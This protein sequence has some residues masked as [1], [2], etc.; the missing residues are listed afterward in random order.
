MKTAMRTLCCLLTLC[1]LLGV[2]SASAATKPSLGAA[3]T[4]NLTAASAT[5]SV[6][7][8]NPS[9]YKITECG[10]SLWRNEN[11]K[12][13]EFKSGKENPNTTG[14]A[15]LI[16]YDTAK[17][18]GALKAD[19]S[20]G[21][22]IYAKSTCGTITATGSFK[23][24]KTLSVSLKPVTNLTDTSARIAGAITA[25]AKVTTCGFVIWDAQKPAEKWEKSETINSALTSIDM[26]YDTQKWYKA[27]TPETKYEYVLWAATSAGR[28]YSPQGSF[29]TAKKSA[30][31][32]LRSPM[33]VEIWADTYA[34]G[35]GHENSNYAALDMYN[36]KTGNNCSATLNQPIFAVAAGR[37]V[38][39]N[40]ANGVVIIEH[41]TPLT[42]TNGVTYAKWYSSYGHMANIPAAFDSFQNKAVNVTAGALLGTAHAKGLVDEKGKP[43]AA[44]HLHFQINK[45]N[46][47]TT[48]DPK[49]AISPYFVKFNGIVRYGSG[50]IIDR[51]IKNNLPTP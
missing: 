11:G 39:A 14:S 32:V 9:K 1:L 20:Y 28:E 42:T 15:F 4:T 40:R 26:W 21:F 7:L 44:Y 51:K 46:P 41:T 23:T 37:V 8:K 18:Y 31:T 25:R 47:W 17:W 43:S 49:S 24:P 3:Q 13:V 38:Q 16:F 50:P 34:D 35:K 12:C 36:S 29:T 6:D 27:L 48:G 10:F 45:V 5:I 19:S 22:S 2:T 30:A 33:N